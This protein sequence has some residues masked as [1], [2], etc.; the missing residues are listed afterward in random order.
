MYSPALTDNCGMC[1][2]LTAIVFTSQVNRAGEHDPD[3][4][5]MDQMGR[6]SKMKYVGWR[7]VKGAMR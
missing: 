4:R 1:G 2:S 7:D 6:I 5:A 3:H